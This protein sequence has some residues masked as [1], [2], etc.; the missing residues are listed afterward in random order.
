MS[1]AKK[2]DPFGRP[3]DTSAGQVLAPDEVEAAMADARRFDS[4]PIEELAAE[5]AAERDQAILDGD[6][7]GD[8]VSDADDLADLLKE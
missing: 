6:E 4:T 2:L 1:D 7:L 3:L 5:L 8:V